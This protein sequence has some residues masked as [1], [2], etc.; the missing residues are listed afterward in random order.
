MIYTGLH[1]APKQII[2]V[3]IQE[4]ID[5]AGFYCPSSVHMYPFAEVVK[6]LREKSANDITAIDGG[7]T[8]E[9]DIPRL[10]Q[11][12]TRRYSN[13]AHPVRK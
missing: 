10:K 3:A 7:I 2:E 9:E 1:Q 8:P 5:R 13:R 6:Q 4:D 11:A 12:L